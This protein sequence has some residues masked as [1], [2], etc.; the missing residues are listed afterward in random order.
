MKN[1]PPTK[2]EKM[3]IKVMVRRYSKEELE[4]DFEDIENLMDSALVNTASRMIGIDVPLKIDGQYLK[5]SIDN[6]EEI[7]N[8]NYPD[9]FERMSTISA[10]IVVRE[11][12][13]KQTDY[14]LILPYLKSRFEDTKDEIESNLW[15]YDPQEGYAEYG[16]SENIDMDFEFEDDGPYPGNIIE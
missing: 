3:L 7:K 6:Y 11:N 5:Y 10:Q 14:E 13:S 16:D 2:N 8:N 4:K 15:N 1:I 12:I 9:Q